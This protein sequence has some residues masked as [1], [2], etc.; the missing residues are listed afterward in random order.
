MHGWGQCE[1]EKRASVP[2][3]ERTYPAR[4]SNH[5]EFTCRSVISDGTVYR[6]NGL[7]RNHDALTVAPWCSGMMGPVHLGSCDAFSPPA[8]R[9][10]VGHFNGDQ[11]IACAT[12]V[13]GILAFDGHLPISIS[14]GTVHGVNPWIERRRDVLGLDRP[15]SQYEL[16][17]L[18]RR[19]RGDREVLRLGRKGGAVLRMS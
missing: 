13:A 2:S 17:G 19:R 10:G 16:R 8:L 6:T 3:P 15:T 12:G 11:N 14:D 7:Y 18:G 4:S 9:I 5:K 1:I